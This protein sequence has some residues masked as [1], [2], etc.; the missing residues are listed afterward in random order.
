MG[1]EEEPEDNKPTL[2][3]EEYDALRQATVSYREELVLRLGG[4]VGLRP[5]E[6]TRIR[7]TDITTY[8]HAGADHYLLGVPDDDGGQRVA[9]LPAGI[10]H[11]L[12]KYARAEAIADDECYLSVTARRI[13]MLVSETAD[14]AAAR[15]GNDRL[16][17]VSSRTLR[18]Y[19]TRRL[20]VEEWVDPR[21]VKSVA[22][23][24]RL[25]TLAPYLD[26]PSRAD[27][28][29]AFDQTSANGRHTGETRS[30]T[31]P[32]G[33]LG[34][35]IERIRAVG[36]AI[37]ET[38]TRE[39][40]AD[41]ACK[42]LIGGP[43]YATAWVAETEGE[44]L[45]VLASRGVDSDRIP[46]VSEGAIERALDDGAV[47]MTDSSDG[48]RAWVAGSDSVGAI[49]P[50]TDGERALG[51]VGVGTDGEVCG[52]YER[53]VLADLGAR[54]GHAFTAAEQRK[55]LL[56]D[57]VVELVLECRDGDS[58]FAT[59][60]RTHDCS[61]SLE[62]V[63][64]GEGQSLLYFLTV[65]GVEPDPVVAWAPTTAPVTDARLVR[66]SGDEALVELVVEGQDISTVLVERGATIR[67]IQASAGTQ[68]VVA[69]VSADADVR[70]LL[71]DVTA[72]FPETE[73]M[74]KRERERAS[75]SSPSFRSSLRETL[76]EKQAAVLQA[77]YHAGYFEWPR[78]STAEELA[79][80]I[81]ITSPTLHNHLRRAQQKLLS[82]FFTEQRPV[83]DDTPWSGA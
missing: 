10:E 42:E 28:V 17:T 4:E 45:T 51:V 68:E 67:D 30:E 76:T 5:G 73:L 2:G 66:D 49:V 55:F 29:G 48:D 71:E 64:P 81:G 52:Q 40:I 26:E 70:A 74:T 60:S 20:L 25:E 37:A 39:G 32:G 22:G 11:D 12:R 57:T 83:S 38:S 62:G 36:T 44:H 58:F 9:Y 79:D 50:V 8:E 56:A 3:R 7:P 47:V 59:L 33:R 63:V 34:P 23:F 69:E 53:T 80:A 77:A 15:T 31:A 16:E 65:A 82:A 72:A 27:I 14:R 24:Q 18:D 19:F 46:T 41:R 1:I 78:G 21:V 75:E 6:M 54:L 13:Q 61:V 35:L 43:V